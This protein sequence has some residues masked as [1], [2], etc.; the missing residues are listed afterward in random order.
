MA[1]LSDFTQEERSLLVSVPYRVGM[2]V[3][4]VEED[5]DIGMDNKRERQALELGI[6]R[7]AGAHRKM[8]FAAS[9]MH[10]VQRAKSNWKDWNMISD[11]ASVLHDLEKAIALCR[12]KISAAELKQY[13]QAIWQTGIVVAQAY[14]E[15]VDPDNEMHFDRFIAWMG[16]FI[17]APKLTKAPENMSDKEKTALKKLR[18]VLK[19]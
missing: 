18:A 17:S 12:D 14:G 13:K 6:R 7:M 19:G 4:D 15:Q 3:S 5:E 9:V 16:S 10:E 2:W 8:P 11:E 1:S